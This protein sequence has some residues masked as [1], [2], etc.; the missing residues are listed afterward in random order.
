MALKNTLTLCISDS[1][2]KGTFTDTTGVYDATNNPYGWGA[3]NMQGSGVTAATITFQNTT[4]GAD[5]V[6]YNVLSQI[7]STVSG[8]IEF[9]LYEY[10]FE[11]G[12]YTIVYTLT[13]TENVSRTFKKLILCNTRCCI[14]KMWAKVNEYRNTKTSE[15]FN[16]YLNDCL[17]AEALYEAIRANGGCLQD[18]AAEDILDMLDSLC[19]FENCNC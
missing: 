15:A 5:E 9:D 16:K 14:D 2:G 19:N 7:P 3:P 1:C 6:T 4:T 8:D 18:D 17:K 12:I 11:D 10:D 13:G